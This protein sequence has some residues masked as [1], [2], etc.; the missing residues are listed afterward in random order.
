MNTSETN[1]FLERLSIA[2]PSWDFEK[3]DNDLIGSFD[4]WEYYTDVNDFRH[5]GQDYIGSQIKIRYT[6]GYGDPT[7]AENQLH[8][9]QRVISNHSSATGVHGDDEDVIDVSSGQTNPFYDLIPNISFTDED[10]FADGPKRPDLQNNHVWLGELFLVEIPDRSQP[11]K[12]TVYNGIS[13]GWRNIYAASNISCTFE[14]NVVQNNEPILSSGSGGGG[15]DKNEC[16]N[17]QPKDKEGQTQENPILENGSLEDWKYFLNAPSNRW[18]DPPTRFGFEFQ[19][20]DNTLFTDILDFPLGLDADDRFTVS[21]GEMLLG[22]FSPGD[23]VN[24]VEL[25]GEGV[26]SFKITGIDSLLGSDK[27][28]D[29]PFKLAFND[30]YGSFRLRAFDLPETSNPES[31]PEPTSVFSLLAFGLLGWKWQRRHR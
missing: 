31:V 3:S 17:T 9:I 6:P 8:W 1:Y 25:L 29:I 11:K 5:P 22:E 24:F 30:D 15:F 7:P 2:F 28:T 14:D 19:S 16:D 12:V 23:R 26:S 20:I 10:D 13:W 21:V 27:A 4:I 18:F